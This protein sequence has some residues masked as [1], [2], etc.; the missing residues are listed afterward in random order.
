MGYAVLDRPLVLPAT[1]KV[2]DTGSLATATLYSD[3]TKTTVAG[4]IAY[5]FSAQEDNRADAILVRITA[6]MTGTLGQMPWAE[7]KT[8]RLT[9]ATCHGFDFDVDG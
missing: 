3:R 5:S 4:T 2:G 9:S 1:V 8:F 6:A 7:V